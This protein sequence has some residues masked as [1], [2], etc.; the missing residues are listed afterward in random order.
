MNSEEIIKGFS[1]LERDKKIKLISSISSLDHSEEALKGILGSFR[2]SDKEL[3]GKFEKFSE[4]TLS[5]FHL[6]W[7]IVPNVL[8]DNQVYH[9]PVVIEESSVVAAASKA[10]SFWAS[11]GGFHTTE[12]CTI[13]KGQ[14]HFFF[15]DDPQ[16]LVQSWDKIVGGLF[17]DISYLTKNME[18]RGGGILALSLKDAPEIAPDYF[19]LEMQAETVDSMGANFINTI[20]EEI[21]QILPQL[22]KKYTGCADTEILMAIL[23]NYTPECLAGIR[24]ECPV[25]MLNWDKNMAPDDFARRMKWAADIAWHDVGRAVTHN[26]GI[27][28]GV[29][30]V[31]LA[32]GN[33]FRAVEAAGHAW[34]TRSGKYRALSKAYIN[35][36]TFSME[37][38]IPLALGTVGGLTRLHPLAGISLDI[39]GSPD[40]KTLMKIVASVGLAN[41]FAALA[42]LV[43]TGIQKG[44]MKM[45]LQNILVSLNVQPKRFPEI[46]SQFQNKTI[47]VSAVKEYLQENPD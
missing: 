28:N 47:S 24:V 27:Y 46:E 23:S 31:V 44:H 8:I 11:R 41:N 6:P 29:D 40:A 35:D 37:L 5:N 4:N 20:L 17:H 12:L 22:I 10:A 3:Q 7:G 43:T 21:G 38:N 2:F 16:L 32:T 25:H 33:D 9:V 36:D 14:V 30:A 45:H 19:Q 39:L 18:Q 42:S 26:K 34:A 1:R 13:K 15:R